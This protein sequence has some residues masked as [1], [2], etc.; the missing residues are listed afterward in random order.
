MDF[1]K[2]SLTGKVALVTGGSRGIGRASA[3]AFADAGADVV[4]S[5]RKLPDLEGVVEDAATQLRD[6]EHKIIAEILNFGQEISH[7]ET[8]ARSAE[9]VSFRREMLENGMRRRGTVNEHAD[10]APPRPWRGGP[11]ARDGATGADHDEDN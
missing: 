4:V 1:S 11:S 6:D 3:L 9:Q 2:I 5:S 8:T 10:G 7:I